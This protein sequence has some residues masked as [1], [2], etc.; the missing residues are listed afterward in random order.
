MI[1]E[2]LQKKLRLSYLQ[3]KHI[4]PNTY[5][6]ISID[7]ALER[8]LCIEQK[9]IHEGSKETY[10]PIC[11]I[12]PNYYD[13]ED[14]QESLGKPYIKTVGDRLQTYI[15]TFQDYQDFI[16]LVDEAYALLEKENLKHEFIN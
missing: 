5:A 16:M 8:G 10:I 9:V 11:Y 6:L 4:D 13:M 15:I 7:A 14:D 12:Y 1:K 3:E 2:G